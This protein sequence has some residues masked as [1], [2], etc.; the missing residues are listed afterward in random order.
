MTDPSKIKAAQQRWREKNREY[1]RAYARKWAREN[2]EKIKNRAPQKV[3]RSRVNELNR[4]RYVANPQIFR[5]RT[6]AWIAKNPEKKQAQ[7]RNRKARLKQA[8]GCH[9]AEQVLD[10]LKKQKHRCANPACRISIRD[11]YE[12]DHIIPLALGGSNYIANIQ[13]LCR[14]CNRKKHAKHPADWAR[15]NG[16]LI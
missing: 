7:N 1:S 14:T 9:S 8:S 16:L 5:D 11:G 6:D 2:P 13:L 15:E 4:L 3:N 12:G 10:L